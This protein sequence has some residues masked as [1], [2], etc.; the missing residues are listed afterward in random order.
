MKNLKRIIIASLFILA[1]LLIS[2]HIFL[3][4]MFFDSDIGRDFL[5]IDDVVSNRNITLIGPRA[6]G[7]SGMF[8]GPHWIYLNIPFYLIGNGNPVVV[9]FSW[10]LLILFSIISTYY[11]ANKLFGKT[12]GLIAAM[13][14]AF[15]IV[16]FSTGITQS[17]FAVLISPWIVYFLALFIKN[18]KP[19]YLGISLFLSGTLYQFQP[20]FG[21]ITIP[22]TVLITFYEIVKIK[23]YKYL[24]LYIFFSYSIW[25]IYRI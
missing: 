13:I 23:K 5:L 25:F 16:P 7:I 12:S 8:F 21:M 17:F 15:F 22:F 24:L 4:D 2:H 10:V 9:A 1:A 6:D 19:L 18:K 3:N 20:A 11:V 14:Y